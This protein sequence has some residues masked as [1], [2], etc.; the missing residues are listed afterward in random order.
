MKKLD[1]TKVEQQII[2]FLKERAEIAKVS[3]FV[4]GIS[5]GVDSAV[6]STLAAKTGLKK[7]TNTFATNLIQITYNQTTKI[8]LL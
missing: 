3:G 1:Y 8:K 5:G 6:V 7:K 4:I 2:S